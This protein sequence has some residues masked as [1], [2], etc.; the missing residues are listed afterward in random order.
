MKDKKEYKL[1]DD[2]LA[3]HWLICDIGLAVRNNEDQYEIFMSP[4]EK[5]IKDN[6]LYKYALSTGDELLAHK[7]KLYYRV[8]TDEE[9]G[10]LSETLGV[11]IL[12]SLPEEYD[13]DYYVDAD[14]IDR[15]L[16]LNSGYRILHRPY[17]AMKGSTHSM[18]TLN[19]HTRG[20][21][22]A[23][24]IGSEPVTFSEYL[25]LFSKNCSK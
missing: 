6:P 14:G 3:L 20:G 15:D 2:L 25:E 22:D 1:Y 7:L 12:P 16:L 23:A 17:F 4:D 10:W 5:T 9:C 24:K 19:Q 11:R 8:A 21:I 13:K 18:C